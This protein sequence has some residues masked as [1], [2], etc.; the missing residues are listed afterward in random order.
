MI[1]LFKKK[2]YILN[3]QLILFEVTIFNITSSLMILK[4][5]FFAKK[6]FQKLTERERIF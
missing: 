4:A 2:M 5:K 6:I 3:I 1:Y